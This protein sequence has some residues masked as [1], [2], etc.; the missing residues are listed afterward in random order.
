MAIEEPE[1]IHEEEPEMTHRGSV[2]ETDI[3]Q[4][5]EQLARMRKLLNGREAEL[6][7]VK[8]ELTFARGEAESTRRDAETAQSEAETAKQEMETARDQLDEAGRHLEGMRQELQATHTE[9][10]LQRLRDLEELRK[11]FDQE[12]KQ[13][14]E[15]REREIVEASEWRKEMTFER[16][17]LRGH[18][19]RL[20][21][22][23][24]LCKVPDS[25]DSGLSSSSLVSTP[26]ISKRG[27]S[28]RSETLTGEEA[29]DMPSNLSLLATSGSDGQLGATSVE[30]STRDMPD[31]VAL[32]HTQSGV[33]DSSTDS[34]PKSLNSDDPASGR[35]RSME[36]R[37]CV[38]A[39]PPAETRVDSGYM[40]QTHR[41]T[42][43]QEKEL[44]VVCFPERLWGKRPLHRH[45]EGPS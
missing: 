30:E 21:E 41:V 3:H 35:G 23:L 20:R 9:L 1:R 16:N 7:E 38:R 24:G 2:S 31:T 29:A 11:E 5:L 42:F 34:V 19:E 37:Q 15:T 13:M 6:T 28:T 26:T 10:E 43:L 39:S 25:E 36:L 22:R 14:R 12:R 45:Q 33:K 40:S 44:V 17:Q 4:V 27:P 8:S 32:E 18:V